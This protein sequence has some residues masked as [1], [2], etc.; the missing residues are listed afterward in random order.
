M[1]RLTTDVLDTARGRPAAGV[2]V[3]LRAL[4][5]AGRFRLITTYGEGV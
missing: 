2:R 5:G 3:E 4:D 1:G